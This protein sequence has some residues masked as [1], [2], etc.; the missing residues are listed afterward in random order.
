MT[1]SPDT[2][3]SPDAATPTTP[4]WQPDPPPESPLMRFLN[5][6]LQPR[7]PSGAGYQRLFRKTLLSLPR[8][9]DPEATMTVTRLI[10]PPS[11]D[12]PPFRWQLLAG[13]AA[14]GT[15]GTW[16]QQRA[17][18][19]I[20]RGNLGQAL[21]DVYDPQQRQRAVALLRPCASGSDESLIRFLRTAASDLS[22]AGRC[23]DWRT[24]HRDLNIWYRGWDSGADGLSDKERIIRRWVLSISYRSGT[25]VSPS[26]DRAVTGAPSS[27]ET[28]S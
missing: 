28:P 13:L 7:R 4:T 26:S 16:H 22:K 10:T 11:S 3:A 14:A 8:E 15:W 2:V 25:P 1:S 17:Q 12:V 5:T 27:E 21:G 6:Q 20:G 23:P 24:V 9:V 19:N 18:G